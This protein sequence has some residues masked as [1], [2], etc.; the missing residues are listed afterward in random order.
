MSTRIT[1]AN[2]TE[3]EVCELGL[4]V[5]D[6]EDQTETWVRLTTEQRARLIT[7]LRPAR[8]GTYD[9]GRLALLPGFGEYHAVRRERDAAVARAE[10]SE[11]KCAELRRELVAKEDEAISECH[12]A[13][14]ERDEWK[15]RAEA[16][17][18]RTAP[19]VSRDDIEKAIHRWKLTGQSRGATLAD[20]LHALV[21]GADPAVYVVRESDVEAQAAL[22]NRFGEFVVN[23]TVLNVTTAEDCREKAQR[24]LDA[25]ARCEGIARAIEAEAV[26]DPVEAKARVEADRR[27]S[28]DPNHAFIEGALWATRHALGQEAS[29][30]E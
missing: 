10:Q 9:D 12:R 21:S 8:S 20:D 23:G 7:A 15:A 1:A 17:E 24:H 13:Y 26:V 29:S 14:R 28:G 27:Y 6:H 5:I 25:A 4:S 2:G 3:I 18:A 19:A 22:R 30:D 16:A 11:R